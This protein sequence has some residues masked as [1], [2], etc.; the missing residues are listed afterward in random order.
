[1]VKN[2]KFDS[3]GDVLTVD[4]VCMILHIGKNSAYRLLQS[5][6]IPNRRIKSKYL[7]PKQGL[8]NY[9]NCA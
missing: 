8:I 1:M 2:D 9:L 4:D 6:E 7:I 5:N 3:Y